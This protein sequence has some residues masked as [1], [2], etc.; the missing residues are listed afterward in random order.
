MI[1][2][3][4][5]ID[6]CDVQQDENGMY[7]TAPCSYKA[8]LLTEKGFSQNTDGSFIKRLSPE[9]SA[10]LQAHSNTVKVTLPPAEPETGIAAIRNA[11]AK[12]DGADSLC[13]LAL[14]IAFLGTLLGFLLPKFV[15]PNGNLYVIWLFCIGGGLLAAMIILI[16][17]AV[18]YPT[19]K[20]RRRMIATALALAVYGLLMF[21]LIKT[22][23]DFLD[24]FWKGCLS[25]ECRKC[26]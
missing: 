6:G 26:G 25:C 18:R 4:Y 9:E 15:L 11:Q 13:S 21:Y 24:I 22:F 14:H 5:G 16:A 12:T 8:E 19:R 23:F 3:Y 2:T 20:T 17:A 7:L 10:Y 1:V